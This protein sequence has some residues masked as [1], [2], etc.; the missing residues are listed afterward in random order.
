MSLI[1]SW[2]GLDDNPTGF[3]M[4]RA[5]EGSRVH[6]VSGSSTGARSESIAIEI[7]ERREERRVVQVGRLLNLYPSS[8]VGRPEQV[9]GHKF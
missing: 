2:L 3:V 6:L 7:V 5:C 4:P 8:R 9:L 1:Q